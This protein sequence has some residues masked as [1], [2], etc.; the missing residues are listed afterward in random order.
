MGQNPGR[1]AYPRPAGLA[2]PHTLPRLQSRGDVMYSSVSEPRIECR[3]D[4]MDR[5]ACT[6]IKGPTTQCKG[7]SMSSIQLPGRSQASTR[8]D[9]ATEGRGEPEGGRPA[10]PRPAGLARER[11]DVKQLSTA[12][13]SKSEPLSKSR[14]PRLGEAGRPHLEAPH[15]GSWHGS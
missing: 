12:S 1:P 13:R 4:R 15:T 2:P 6:R 10:S 9:G 14:W 3:F 8:N 11:V 7:M 5:K